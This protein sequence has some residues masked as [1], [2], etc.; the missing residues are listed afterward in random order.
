MGEVQATVEVDDT[1]ARTLTGIFSVDP[2]SDAARALFA[3]MTAAAFAEYMLYATG[4][5]VPAGVRD[6]R[7][8]R[9]RLLAENL[10]AG[11]PTENQVAQLFHLTAAQARNL[12]AGT[13]ARYPSQLAKSLDEAARDALRQ[14]TKGD[15]DHTI[16]ITASAS[17]AAY[18]REVVANASSAQA[19]A[20]RTDAS[21]RYDVT[22]SAAEVLCAHLDMPITDINALPPQ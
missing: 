18:L 21:N 10:P 3:G 16:R 22:R 5:R 11:L 19:P 2:G 9:L 14:A 13:R 8:L 1:A 4:E 7:E 20:K 6:L 12:I 15:N 17:V